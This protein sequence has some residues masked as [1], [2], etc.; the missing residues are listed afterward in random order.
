ML[1]VV[2]FQGW[3]FSFWGKRDIRKYH[4]KHSLYHSHSKLFHRLL[5]QLVF[6]FFGRFYKFYLDV[7]S[8]RIALVNIGTCTNAIHSTNIQN[9]NSS[10]KMILFYKLFSVMS[11]PCTLLQEV[12][13][14]F[15]FRLRHFLNHGFWINQQNIGKKGSM[16][17]QDCRGNDLF[18]R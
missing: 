4:S 17:N 3:A 11:Y 2:V 1:A 6:I 16:T 9:S 15:P 5:N 8:S 13:K 14:H 7:P 12:S 18:I 10:L